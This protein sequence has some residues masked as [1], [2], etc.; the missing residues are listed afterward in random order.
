MQLGVKERQDQNN[1]ARVEPGVSGDIV[2]PFQGCDPCCFHF[3]AF[4][5]GLSIFDPFR[6]A[7]SVHLNGRY[8]AVPLINQFDW[9]FTPENHG[10]AAEYYQDL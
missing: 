5:T 7:Q 6:V 9:A 2:Q 10:Q 3:P 8:G 1:P 4:H